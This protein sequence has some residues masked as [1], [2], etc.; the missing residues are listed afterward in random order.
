MTEQRWL[1]IIPIALVMY[2][3][4]YIDRTNI[5][6]ALDPKLSP[7]M[8]FLGMDD[9]IKGNA[10]GIFFFGYLLLQIPSGYLAN[11]WSPRKLISIFLVCWGACAIGCGLV[12]TTA[13]FKTMRFLLG[14]AE[15][16]VFP[17]TLVLLCNWFPRAER[18]RA[19]AYWNLCQPL[20]VAGAAPIT[21]ALLGVWG[22][23]AALIVEGA[24]P[25]IWLPVWW[26]CISDHPRE[27]KWIAKE[28]REHLETTLA[29]ETTDLGKANEGSTWKALTEPSVLVALLAMVPI[30][31]L[32]NCAAYGCNT[33]LSEALKGHGRNFTPLQTGVLYAIPYLVAAVVMVL[34]SRHSDEKQERR[35]HV[36]F[37]YAVAGFCLIASVLS[38]RYS[39]W[40]SFGFL[41]FAIQGPFAGLAPFWSIPSETMPRV[42]LGTVMGLVNAFGNLG[43]WAGNYAFGWLKEETGDIVVPFSVLGGGLLVAALLCFLLPKRKVIPILTTTE[44]GTLAKADQAGK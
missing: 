42:V 3:I 9:K 36:A 11:R 44:T 1:R 6:L 18:A 23:R 12:N 38:S 21:G 24:L 15:S 16:G 10:V 14:V 28:E 25:I 34:I 7:M 17:A 37:V 41:C 4:S 29:R 2:T 32:Q 5:A 20:A 30:Y 43:G 8:Q 39:F 35:G 33:F 27:A 31:F 26:F 13:Q 19:N 40:L 22:W